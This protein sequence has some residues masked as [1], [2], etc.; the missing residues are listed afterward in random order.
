MNPE[1]FISEV[2]QLWLE[3]HNLQG[4]VIVEKRP[5]TET[6]LPQTAKENG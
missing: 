6:T 3:E 2:L 1:R 4:T 5:P